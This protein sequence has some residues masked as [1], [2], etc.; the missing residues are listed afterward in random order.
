IAGQRTTVVFGVTFKIKRVSDKDNDIYFGTFSG[1]SIDPATTIH[2]NIF[3]KLGTA[4]KQ[5]SF[6]PKGKEVEKR[7]LLLVNRYTFANR[8]S[9]VIRGLSYAY[10]EIL[11][12]SNIEEVWFQNPT[13]HGAPTHVL[14]YTKE[15]LQQYDTKRLDL[16][17]INAELFGAWF[18]SF[19]SIGDE[20]KE[21]LFAGLR[22][23]LKSKKPHQVFDDKLTREEMARLGL[24]LVD[25][26]R[27]D[28]TVWLIDQFIDDPDPVEPEHYEGDPES[29]YHEKI[30]AGEDPHII[31]TVRG[32]LAWVIQKLALRK[33]YIIKALDYTKTLLRYKNLYAKLQA[34]I[35]L[36]EIAAR[37]QWL[38]ELN[39]QEYKEFHDVTFDLL[40]NY[41]KYPP[42]AKR[43]THVFY[44]FQDL[45]TEEALEVLERLKITDESAPLFIYFGI[46]RQRHYKNQDGR[47]KKCFD[48]KR[49]KKNLEEII[50]NNDDQYTN[51]R[52]SIAW[53][54]WKLLSKNPDEFD[55][56]SPYISLFL[57]QPYRKNIYDDIARIIKE[58]IEKKPEKCTPW[59]EKLLSNIAIYVKTNKQ[60]GRNIWLMPEKIINYIA[61][62]HPEK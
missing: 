2:K 9:E 16:T 15:F 56:I 32:N 60:E 25:K 53:N 4:N 28:E 14:L 21:K 6:V 13:E 10:Q 8:I 61:Y 44:Y 49:L 37:R 47:D 31:T 27:F 12:Y 20:H 30:I 50:K 59:F 17:K 1:G 35:P 34:I 23:F 5:L 24:W 45:T 40:R 52:G 38:E 57:E 54:F 62:H 58:W 7:I 55:A 33:N 22:T 19:E 48:P 11:S 51:L 18:S 26:E 39:P 36:I 41:A 43:L 46:F 3:N 29:N 42:I